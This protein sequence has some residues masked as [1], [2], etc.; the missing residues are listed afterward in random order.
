MSENNFPS[1]LKERERR[2]IIREPPQL[3]VKDDDA[4]VNP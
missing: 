1:S 4:I 3:V 2:I